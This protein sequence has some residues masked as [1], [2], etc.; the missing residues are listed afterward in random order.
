MRV[1]QGFD[2]HTTLGAVRYDVRTLPADPDS[3]VAVT[4]NLMR[5]RVS[6]DSANPAFK[7]RAQQIAGQGTER[8]KTERLYW[9]VKN[10]IRFQPDEQTGGG[11]AGFAPEEVIET[12]IRP[13]DMAAYV[14]QGVAVGD[15]DDF[16]SYLAALLK[17]NG[18]NCAFITVAADGNVPNQFSHVYVVAWP[19][20][21]RL[22]LDASHGEYPGWEVPNN[23]GKL[24]EWP[25][26]GGLLSL[27]GLA[28]IGTGIYFGLR[29]A[30]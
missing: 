14:D 19:D 1:A 28:A 21:E 18:I 30:A 16:S 24:Q 20:G 26:G 22:A 3:Q 25:C 2:N 12:I 15:C 9:H 4:L 17:A 13:V 23:Y 29:R 5:E 6:Q 8:Q 7:A 11:I 10:G 27:L